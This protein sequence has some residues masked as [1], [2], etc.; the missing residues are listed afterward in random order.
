MPTTS[1]KS[2]MV[3]VKSFSATSGVVLVALLIAWTKSGDGFTCRGLGEVEGGTIR[4][5]AI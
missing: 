4:L 5:C 3:F 2:F 1:A